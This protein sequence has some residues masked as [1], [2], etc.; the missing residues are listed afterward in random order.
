MTVVCRVA[1]TY[2][3]SLIKGVTNAVSPLPDSTEAQPI[4]F[5]R[6]ASCQHGERE[7][8]T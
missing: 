5:G 2:Q 6:Q 7:G 3:C 1:S 4:R 8:P